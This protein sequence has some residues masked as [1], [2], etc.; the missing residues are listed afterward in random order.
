MISRRMY[1]QYALLGFLVLPALSGCATKSDAI[2]IGV[3]RVTENPVRN[4]PVRPV[5]GTQSDLDA[6][7]LIPADQ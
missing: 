6:A 2:W 4:V 7:R 1:G 5:R 3:P